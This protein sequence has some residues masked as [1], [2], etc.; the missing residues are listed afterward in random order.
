M[1][2]QN[3]R[4]RFDG[5]AWFERQ[6]CIR[7]RAALRER[8]STALRGS[9]EYRAEYSHQLK[10]FRAERAEVKRRKAEKYAERLK[11]KNADA[12]TRPA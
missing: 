9:A 6:V 8:G 10:L 12:E 3:S 2:N 7:T 1:K 5:A 4:K 11:K